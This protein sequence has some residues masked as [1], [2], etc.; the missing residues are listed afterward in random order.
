L[1]SNYYK[2]KFNLLTHT[3]KIT[4]LKLS[5]QYGMA[6]IGTINIGQNNKPLTAIFDTGSSLIWFADSACQSCKL[7]DIKNPYICHE[8]NTCKDNHKLIQE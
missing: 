8:S 2:F 6:Y 5:T 3:K 7:A 4:E 1:T